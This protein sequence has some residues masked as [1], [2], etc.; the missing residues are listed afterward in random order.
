MRLLSFVKHAAS[1]QIYINL[2]EE[3]YC[4]LFN[5]IML[6][7]LWIPLPHVKNLDGQCMHQMDV[8]EPSQ[9]GPVQFPRALF[10]GNNIHKILRERKL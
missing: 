5:R 10:I 7:W 2:I 6:L 1:I 3:S 8:L 4:R 9:A